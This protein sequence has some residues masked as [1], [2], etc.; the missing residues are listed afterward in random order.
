MEPERLTEP[1]TLGWLLTETDP[2]PDLL[3]DPDSEP[4]PLVEPERLTEPE[5]LGWLLTETDPD[6]EPLALTDDDRLDDDDNDELLDAEVDTSVR[7]DSDTE[8]DADDDTLTLKLSWDDDDDN[9]DSTGDSRV[10]VEP[11]SMPPTTGSSRNTVRSST[12]AVEPKNGE[13]M[14]WRSRMSTPALPGAL[15]PRGRVVGFQFVELPTHRPDALSKVY[16]LHC[17]VAAVPCSH[18]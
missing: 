9:D 1:E 7:L 6:V 15:A 10:V 16:T 12:V 11:A 13:N 8:F 3:A 5:M 14:S 2:E 4:L 18:T 17:P